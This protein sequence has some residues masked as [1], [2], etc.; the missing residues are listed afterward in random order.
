[1]RSNEKQKRRLDAVLDEILGTV[2]VLPMG[3][4]SF[5]KAVGFQKTRGLGPQGSPVYASVIAD[6]ERHPAA[7]SCFVARNPKDFS[8]E[9]VEADLP[10]YGCQPLLTFGAG[11]RVGR[12]FSLPRAK[13]LPLL[14]AAL[15]RARRD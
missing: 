10:R 15:R 4:A 14:R 1:M 3:R 2:R 5:G 9:D 7:R 12:G 8:D 11:F 6:L 13:E